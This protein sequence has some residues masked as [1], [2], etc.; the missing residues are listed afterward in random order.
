MITEQYYEHAV[1]V[2]PVYHN[3]RVSFYALELWLSACSVRSH[4]L[5]KSSMVRPLSYAGTG[6]V[7]SEFHKALH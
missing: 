3:N 4:V 2:I 6:L 7:D 5:V 1:Q